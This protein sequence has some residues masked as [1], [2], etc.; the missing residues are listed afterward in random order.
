MPRN[1]QLIKQQWKNKTSNQELYYKFERKLWS[2][3]EDKGGVVVEI[4]SSGSSSGSGSEGEEEGEE[5]E[6]VAISGR[7]A[8]MRRMWNTFV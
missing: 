3:L 2:K 6:E 7:R 1:I 8:G 5:E 4:E